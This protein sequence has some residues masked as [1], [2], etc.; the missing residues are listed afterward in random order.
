MALGT[1]DMRGAK[2]SFEALL[3][4]L[5]KVVSQTSNTHQ[6]FGKL[7]TLFVQVGSNLALANFKLN[8]VDDCASVCEK[9]LSLEPNHEKCLYRRGLCLSTKAEQYN[10]SGDYQSALSY[11]KKSR[12]DLETVLKIDKSTK[13]VESKLTAVVRAIIKI[14]TENGWEAPKS[15]QKKVVKV[16]IEEAKPVQK[17]VK[18][19]VGIPKDK[20]D[21]II[22]SAVS[23]TTSKFAFCCSMESFFSRR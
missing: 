3:S 21:N 16:Q 22:S 5:E 13:E 9:V 12:S 20:F 14:E 10:A 7:K 1:G 19:P 2:K 23:Q 4:D 11:Y 17:T 18:L 6:E 8:E 15:T